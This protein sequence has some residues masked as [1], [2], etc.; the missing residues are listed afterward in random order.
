MTEEQTPPEFL[1]WI[2][3]ETTGLD[4]ISDH[5]LEIGWMITTQD[6]AMV[7]TGGSLPINPGVAD[8][9]LFRNDDG[10]VLKMHT[11][12]G[13]LD[14][15]RHPSARTA[16]DAEKTIV[17]AM[18][19]V[20]EDHGGVATF[21]LAGSGVAHLDHRFI[22]AQFPRIAE[23]LN[24][25]VIDVGVVRR[26]VRDV[27]RIVVDVEDFRDINHRGYDDI[28]NHYNEAMLYRHLMSEIR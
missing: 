14:A 13:L 9:V 3:L 23:R 27:A 4:E 28:R 15:I 16:P 6:L 26:F 2:D 7:H 18:N 10:Y 11:E 17:A 25:Y 24:Y 21:T 20:Q 19:S 12:N 5:V 8:S 22:K 1:L